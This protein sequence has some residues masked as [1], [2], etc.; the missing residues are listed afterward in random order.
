MT[1]VIY[2]PSAG[3]VYYNVSGSAISAQPKVKS[4]AL[5]GVG[6]TNSYFDWAS[7]V[8][9]NKGLYGSRIYATNKTGIFTY[10][11]GGSVSI[12][13]VAASGGVAVYTLNSHD[14]VVGS[15]IYV[16]DTNGK[17][18][19]VQRVTEKDTNTFTTDKTYISG[20]GTLA[21]YLASG[22]LAYNPARYSVIRKVS[23]TINGTAN[24]AL[25]TGA[26]PSKYR[27]TPH[28][29]LT[30]FRH[31][32]KATAIRAGYWNEYSGSWSTAPTAT[33]SS[34][35]DIS[36]S[37]VTTGLADHEANVSRSFRGELT[38]M[39]GSLTP[40]SED[41]DLPTG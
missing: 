13:S 32:G 23:T 24:T 2:N 34:I 20:A 1:S 26:A 17:V 7:N 41:Y 29:V 11:N 36:R 4:G 5:C 27:Q 10:T 12:T 37:T 14:L 33:N 35:G 3:S 15:L 19:G 40:N 28:K 22:T 18:T 39:D 31:D 38:Y 30:A 21:Y 8:P 25:L 9:D 6:P 16:T